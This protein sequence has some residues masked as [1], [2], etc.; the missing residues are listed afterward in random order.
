MSQNLLMWH[1]LLVHR[2][3]ILWRPCITGVDFLSNKSALK[4]I[5]Q[6]HHFHFKF[7][8]PGKVFLKDTLDGPERMINLLIMA[9]IPARSVIPPGL[10]SERQ[11][12]LYDK[13]RELVPPNLQDLLCPKPLS[14]PSPMRII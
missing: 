8:H 9:T 10:L 11:H 13:I 7:S 2:V 4:G 1:S 14:W 6:M 3:V 12:Y 5:N